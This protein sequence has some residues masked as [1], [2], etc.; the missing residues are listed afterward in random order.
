[1][2]DVR[3]WSSTISDRRPE[4]SVKRT[5]V[6]VRARRWIEGGNGAHVH[7]TVSMGLAVLVELDVEVRGKGLGEWEIA[8]A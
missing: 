5:K 6:R 7:V 2:R 3:G 1:L 8:N 4:R